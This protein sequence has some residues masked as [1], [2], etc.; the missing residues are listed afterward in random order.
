MSWNL[1]SPNQKRQEKR[2]EKR[3]KEQSQLMG[4]SD[5]HGRCRLTLPVRCHTH[6]TL[7]GEEGVVGLSTP[8][9]PLPRW[10]RE[11]RLLPTQAWGRDELS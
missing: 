9:L 11:V 10:G 4:N 3:L 8:N 2:R 7:L 1:F 6:P 5:K